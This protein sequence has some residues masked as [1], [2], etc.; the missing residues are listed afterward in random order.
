MDKDTF[1]TLP[2]EE[3]LDFL[4]DTLETIWNIFKPFVIDIE[5]RVIHL[6][7]H[8][9]FIE[10]RCNN[11]F[12]LLKSITERLNQHTVSPPLRPSPFDIDRLY[13]PPPLEPSPLIPDADDIF[14]PL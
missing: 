12:D 1:K 13:S 5:N 3:K 8:I 6:E 2:L 9:H 11:H 7:D 10:T 4:Y 14:N